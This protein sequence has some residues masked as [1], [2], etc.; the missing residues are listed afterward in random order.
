MAVGKNMLNAHRLDIVFSLQT[1]NR[2]DF[3]RSTL[4]TGVLLEPNV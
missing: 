4:A 3:H 1:W 2:I